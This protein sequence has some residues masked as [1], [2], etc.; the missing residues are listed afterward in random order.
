M[1]SNK[2][3]NRTTFTIL[4]VLTAVGT[5]SMSYADQEAF[6]GGTMDS[7]KATAAE[8]LLKDIPVSVWTDKT[9]YEHNEAIM[10]TGQVANVA[11]G[12]PV[13]V[14]VVSPLKL[15]CLQLINSM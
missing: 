15:H 2:M 14:I 3:N 11:S 1:I 8:M 7:V 13:T 12:F 4:A 6:V 9:D 5:I 10:V